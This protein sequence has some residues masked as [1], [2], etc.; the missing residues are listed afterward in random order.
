MQRLCHLLE[1]TRRNAICLLVGR[2]ILKAIAFDPVFVEAFINF[3]QNRN[4]SF[5]SAVVLRK[6]AID[7]RVHG[8]C[9]VWRKEANRLLFRDSL[10]HYLASCRI[11]VA[12]LLKRAES[13]I[14]AWLLAFRER[15][16][17]WFRWLVFIRHLH[18]SRR[19]RYA[20]MPKR[21]H[22][23]NSSGAKIGG[24]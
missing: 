8:A 5:V 19:I 6:N 14:V 21:P 1:R 7:N 12:L 20:I 4:S 22:A 13:R 15:N 24:P 10:L 3:R 18:R 23:A 9:L 2:H 16:S 11:P 17:T